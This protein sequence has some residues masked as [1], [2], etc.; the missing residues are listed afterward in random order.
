MGV[1]LHHNEHMKPHSNLFWTP[2]PKFKRE[3]FNPKPPVP[4]LGWKPATD[5][6]DLSQAEVISFDVETYDPDLRDFGPGW[7]RGKGH[8]IGIALGTNDGYSQYFPIRHKDG[9]NHDPQQILAY[10]RE[11]LGRKNQPKV[12]HNL[13]YDVGWCE[14]EGIHIAGDLHCT[15]TA[16]KIINHSAE[17]PLEAVGQRYMKEGK[18]ST[19]LYEWAWSYWGKGPRPDSGMRDLA[20]KNLHRI[21]AELV[22]FYAESDVRLPPQIAIHQFEKLE[23]YG[24]WD[25]Y[26]MECDLI[27]L[28]VQMRLAGVSVDLDRAETAHVEF[29]KA[30]DELQR[31][32]DIIAGKPINTG[33]VLEI[34]PVFD[35]LKIIY[36]R[37][38]KTGKPSF[39]GEFL[40]T[41]EHPLA[42]KIVEIEDLKKMQ[43]S[44]VQ[45]QIL[46][47][48]V[49]GKVFCSFNPLRAVTG[50]MSCSS[51]NL[52]Q[53]PSRGHLA[54][55]VKRCFIP[56]EGHLEWR[57][58]DYASIE[59]RILAHFAVG[60]GSQ[61]LRAEYNDD[62]DVD[63][64]DLTIKMV[65]QT[66]GILLDRKPAKT[67]SF[68]LGYGASLRK[69]ALMLGLT[70]EQAT[71]LFEAY[72]AGMPFVK[73]TSDMC[74]KE[75]E[76]KGYTTT[77]LGR[78]SHFDYWEPRFS[79]KGSPRPF[80]MKYKD[81]VKFYGPDLKRAHLHKA[82]NHKIQGT[83]ADFMKMAMVTC[84]QT[85]V[86]DV[87]GVPRLVI[88]DALDFSV[89]ENTSDVREG[90]AEMRQVMQECIK[91]KVPIRVDGHKGESWG[92]AHE[93]IED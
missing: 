62:P 61:Q 44:F 59:S 84:Y 48:N 31:E 12:G 33:S 64:H 2:D 23:K 69:L 41:I 35:K 68:G 45:G 40:K 6:P 14:H 73:A 10:A 50:R 60:P 16:E 77:I 82:A 55:V 30:I 58:Y 90:F 74:S 85:G 63:Y 38:E 1:C 4:K 22:G 88:H 13:L 57:D 46:D 91:F 15:W 36:P 54:K 87:I 27:P 83:A 43:S 7:A 86:F 72:H 89:A 18:E 65:K 67:I 34:A 28:L 17:A 47:A 81:A 25:V 79:P 66:T 56:D 70:M 11:Q 32:I 78:R 76:Q 29:G 9:F 92:E 3:V 52:Q 8:I 20:M 53:T 42:A 26:R 24:L 93:A 80:A 19:E 51:P 39:K 5:F 75:A 71:P 21:P 37:T 49:N